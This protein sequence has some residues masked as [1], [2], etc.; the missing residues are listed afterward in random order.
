[1]LRFKFN[2]G[3]CGPF[4]LSQ[5]QARDAI[6]DE[7]LGHALIA[8][9]GKRQFSRVKVKISRGSCGTGPTLPR[10]RRGIY[11]YFDLEEFLRD[12]HGPAASPRP[13]PGSFPALAYS[14]FC[15]NIRHELAPLV[16]CWFKTSVLAVAGCAQRVSREPALL[17]PAFLCPAIFPILFFI[18]TKT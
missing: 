15:D 6:Q 10:A 16:G 7:P 1:M 5:Q 9:I 4:I 14:V 13:A 2:A 18:A 3:D 17:A 12:N 11:V 8:A